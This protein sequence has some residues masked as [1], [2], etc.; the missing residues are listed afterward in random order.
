MSERDPLDVVRAN[1][2]AFSRR[3]VDGMLALYAPD[4]VVAD[5]RKMGLLGTFHGHDELRDYYLGIF[6]AASTMTETLEVLAHR[7]GVVVC[8]CE[9]RGRLASDPDGREMAAPYGLVV[10]IDGGLIQRLEIFD[11]GR[12][13]L[14]ESGLA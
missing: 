13:A 2:A 6:H 14:T 8:D 12:D 1:N 9:L 5:R 3:D 11:D 7:G 10:R 4:A